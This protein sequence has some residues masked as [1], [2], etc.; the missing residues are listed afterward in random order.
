MLGADAVIATRMRIEDGRYTGEIEF[1]AYRENKAAALRE[2]AD[3]RG[4]D[5][6]ESY[7]YS[8]SFT[9]L[10]ML[11]AVG[12]PYAVNPDRALRREAAAR[13]WPVLDFTHPAPL[14]RRLTDHLGDRL[15]RL[16][17]G[18]PA[19]LAR[20]AAVAALAA[21]ALVAWTA[22]RRRSLYARAAQT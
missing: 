1:Y 17:S 5:L 18:Q 12:H 20:P 6:E 16:P 8:D 10:P 3:R 21:G 22:L 15:E 9:D 11:E 13:G 14:R 7:A 4:Y 19:A 2:M